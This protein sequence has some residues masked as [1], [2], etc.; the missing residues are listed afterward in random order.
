MTWFCGA[1]LS[2]YVG[3]TLKPALCSAVVAAA[4]IGRGHLALGVA[5]H[6]VLDRNKACVRQLLLRLR[7]LFV[8]DVRHRHLRRPGGRPDRDGAALRQLRPRGRVLLEDEPG[9]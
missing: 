5:G 4:R 3:L 6:D 2:W 1:L 7:P 9:L 8:L